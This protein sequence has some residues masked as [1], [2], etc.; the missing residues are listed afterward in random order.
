[1]CEMSYLIEY[2]IVM[3]KYKSDK[4]IE[5]HLL[6]IR[7]LYEYV[8]CNILEDIY[9]EHVYDI[10]IN[11]NI[12]NS[13]YDIPKD[14]IGVIIDYFESFDMDN[15]RN[16][17]HNYKIIDKCCEDVEKPLNTDK[18][19]KERLNEPVN[20][21]IIYLNNKDKIKLARLDESIISKD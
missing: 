12:D 2:N 13:N 7:A 10:L 4:D 14:I 11:L 9:D 15:F 1:M 8:V 18:W 3:R 16:S 5:I 6:G 17:F 19:S 20:K 21:W